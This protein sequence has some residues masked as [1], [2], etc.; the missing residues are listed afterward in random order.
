MVPWMGSISAV[1]I[2]IIFLYGGKLVI[3]QEISPAGFVAFFWSIQRLVWPLISLGFVVG[4]IA[5]G[6]AAYTRLEDIFHAV[7]DVVSGSLP[8]PDRV[9]GELEVRGLSFSY[10]EGAPRVLD[11]VSF[12]I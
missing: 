12:R 8:A 4:M 5:R 6:R 1:S 2:V 7:P 9:H 11:D 3:A 10:R